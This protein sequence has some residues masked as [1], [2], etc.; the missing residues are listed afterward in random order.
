M[1]QIC[2]HVNLAKNRHEHIAANPWI[3]MDHAAQIRAP[4]LHTT[5]TPRLYGLRL[6]KTVVT[7]TFDFDFDRVPLD[8]RSDFGLA[9]HFQTPDSR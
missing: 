5:H 3:S 4:T 6:F 9:L 8:L 1:S 7:H 2:P